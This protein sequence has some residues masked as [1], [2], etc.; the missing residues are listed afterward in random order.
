MGSQTTYRSVFPKALRKFN[1]SELAG[2][3]ENHFQI[4]LVDFHNRT[5][6]EVL[7]WGAVIGLGETFTF[8]ELLSFPIYV[9]RNHGDTWNMLG[10]TYWLILPLSIPLWWLERASA[11]RYF[12]WKWVSPFDTDMIG[13]PRAWLYEFAIIAFRAAAGEMLVHLIV[14]QTTAHFGYQ[15]W[16]GLVAVVLFSNGFPIAITMTIWWGMYHRDDDWVISR[17]WW[18]PIEMVNAFG[19]LFLFGAGFY[20]GPALAFLAGLV[21]LIED[22][23]GWRGIF[24]RVFVGVGG[25]GRKEVPPAV[26]R[27]GFREIQ[28]LRDDQL[29]RLFF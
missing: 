19:Y 7:V 13:E 24:A 8:L 25:E 17:W 3:A 10:W 16:V 4:R 29:P 5:D 22:G 27:G 14:A 28:E 11:R 9:L 26:R 23:L 6:G 21:R 20:L 18:A 12:G 1:A 2:C 15:F